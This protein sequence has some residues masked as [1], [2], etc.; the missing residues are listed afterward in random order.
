MA[1][2]LAGVSGGLLASPRRE[3]VQLGSLHFLTS[4]QDIHLVGHSVALLLLYLI[5]L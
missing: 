2:G 3:V 1:Y 4:L 5:L